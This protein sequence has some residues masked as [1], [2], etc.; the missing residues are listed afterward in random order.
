MHL[1]VVRHA[2]AEP[3]GSGPDAERRLTAEGR[4]RFTRSVQGLGAL[5]VA[6]DRVLCSPL[7]RARETAELLGAVASAAPEVTDR[8]AAPPSTAL[9]AEA[10]KGGEHVALV[11]HEPWMG[12]LVS[13]LLVGTPHGASVRMKKGAVCWLAGEPRPGGAQLIAHLP[14]RALRAVA[15]GLPERE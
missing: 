14:P 11:G 3:Y 7:I 1:Y 9:L 15:D 4:E 6:L 2:I 8:L 12:E 13:L 10:A 5:G